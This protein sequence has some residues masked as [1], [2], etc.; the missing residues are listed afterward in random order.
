MGPLGWQLLEVSASREPRRLPRCGGWGTLRHPDWLSVAGPCLLLR[1]LA[2]LPPGSPSAALLSGD[3]FYSDLL[4]RG[5]SSPPLSPQHYYFLPVSLS[6]SLSSSCVSGLVRRSCKNAL[7]VRRGWDKTGLRTALRC[8]L[9]QRV[10]RFGLRASSAFPHI[11][12][13]PELF[14]FPTWH[15]SPVLG[16]RSACLC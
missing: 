10:W 13:G 14:L 15:V 3:Y 4:G 6:L 8:E 2:I 16:E 1:L 11:S 5:E 7:K 9:L 12:E